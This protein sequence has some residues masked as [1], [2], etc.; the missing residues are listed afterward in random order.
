MRPSLGRDAA[1]PGGAA[2]RNLRAIETSADEHQALAKLYGD[3]RRELS[4]YVR[5]MVGA[6][7]PEPEDVVQITF[8]RF[9]AMSAETPIANP[10]A[11]LFR[12]AHNVIVD[13]HRR[14]ARERRRMAD[15]AVRV[16]G[17]VDVSPEDVLLPKEDIARLEAAIA[18]LKPK[19]RTALLMH[20]VDELSFAEIGRRLGLS[21]SGARKLVEQA[22]AACADA[23][24]RGR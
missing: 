3:H 23:M 16:Q 22:F 20:R 19:Q 7:P 24:T 1:A 5:R 4:A 6:G 13:A 17:S 15:E 2:I 8:A 9:A 21:P 18:R 14:L 12:M 10:R 11:F